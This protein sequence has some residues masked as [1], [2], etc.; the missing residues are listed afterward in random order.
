MLTDVLWSWGED[1]LARSRQL[2]RNGGPRSVRDIMGVLVAGPEQL[3]GGALPTLA[4]FLASV[5]HTRR[6][7]VSELM[8]HREFSVFSCLLRYIEELC[9]HIPAP[10]MRQRLIF[11]A[12]YLISVESAFEAFLASRRPSAVWTDYGPRTNIIDPAAALI[13]TPASAAPE[14]SRRKRTRKR[15]VEPLELLLPRACIIQ[16]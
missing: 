15:P 3:K 5:L 13:E 11:V 14:P 10:V 1:W 4:R 2:E 12:W 7:V 16:G 8:N 6:K 9:P